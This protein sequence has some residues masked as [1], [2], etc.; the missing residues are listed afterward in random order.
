M[1]IFKDITDE[2]NLIDIGNEFVS[3]YESSSVLRN[4]WRFRFLINTVLYIYF[5]YSFMKYVCIV[6]M[7]DL[8]IIKHSFQFY[9]YLFPCFPCTFLTIIKK[10]PHLRNLRRSP[11]P[12]SK[13]FFLGTLGKAPS[14]Q[15]TCR[16]PWVESVFLNS[17]ST[18][19]VGLCRVE[20]KIFGAHLKLILWH[21][22]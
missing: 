20:C 7:R 16:R 4:I 9:N 1:N 5:C 6:Y 17:L 19:I 18:S 10:E 8:F 3:L 22:L 14:L 2:L 21:V 12:Q 15:K 13:N 11:R